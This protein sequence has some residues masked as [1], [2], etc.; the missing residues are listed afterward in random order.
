MP[1]RWSLTLPRCLRRWT[2][3][4]TRHARK[5]SRQLTQIRHVVPQLRR[6]R[7]VIAVLLHIR[8]RRIVHGRA[9]G[10]GSDLFAVAVHGPRRHEAPDENH[11]D[12]EAEGGADYDEDEVLGEA[13]VLHVGCVGDGRD[14]RRWI[15]EDAGEGG[16]CL[17]AA[18]AEGDCWLG[19]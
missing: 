9:A 16:R 2:E 6:R 18:G 11:E 3:E 19:I 4:Q 7:T 1:A 10:C 13:G 14:G 8:Q 5:A 12:D 15:A 17:T